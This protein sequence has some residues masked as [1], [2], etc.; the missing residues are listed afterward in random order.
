MRQPSRTPAFTIIPD[1][2]LKRL[3]RQYRLRKIIILA[4]EEDS[5]IVHVV[6]AAV[7][8][9]EEKIVAKEAATVKNAILMTGAMEL[10]PSSNVPST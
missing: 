10:A 5:M 6:G 3:C 9:V 8:A 1:S 4:T 2:V 7:T